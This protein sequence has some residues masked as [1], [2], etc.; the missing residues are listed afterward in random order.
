MYL[1]INHH[2]LQSVEFVLKTQQ[3]IVKDFA[4]ASVEFP[5]DFQSVVYSTEYIL[6]ELSTR[7]RILESTDSRGF[8]QLLYQIDIPESLLPELSITEGFHAQL[9]EIV[10]KREAYKVYL[11]QQFSTP[12]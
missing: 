4:T 9:A 11:R 12:S 3:Q 8:S 2:E 6:S 10:L 1:E 7:L 5:S